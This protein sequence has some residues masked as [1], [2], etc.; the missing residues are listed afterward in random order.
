M[1]IILVIYNQTLADITSFQV[2]NLFKKE[3]K[4]SALITGLFTRLYNPEQYHGETY[5]S[6]LK[7]LITCTNACQMISQLYCRTGFE[8]FQNNKLIS[9]CQ[10]I[11]KL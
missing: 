1:T 10:N 8:F 5:M 11:E 9:N 4:V 3:K 2:H 6:R 7:S